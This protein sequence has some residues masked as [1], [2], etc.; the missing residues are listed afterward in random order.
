MRVAVFGCGAF[1]RVH[2]AALAALG[3]EACGVEPD[4]AMHPPG[5]RILSPEAA[6][7]WCDAAIVVT[8]VQSHVDVSSAVLAAGRAL[9]LEKPATETA[10]EAQ[11]LVDLAE[12]RG[13]IAQVGLYF[14]FH[15]KA[16]ALAA[17]VRDGSLGRVHYAA[18]RFSGL[19]RARADSGALLNDAVHFADLLPWLLGEAPRAVFAAMADP[20]GRGREDLAVLHLR[21]PSGAIGLIEAGCVLPGHWPDAVVP[22]AE[23]R[24]E[25]ILAG[26][27]GMAEVDFAAE[28]FRLRRGR[29]RPDAAGAWWPD[30]AP[31]EDPGA[32]AATPHEVVTAEVSTFL[33]AVR[34]GRALGP[35]LREGALAPALL[36]DAARRSAQEGRMVEIG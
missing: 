31:A 30:H 7:H 24:K 4:P 21:F 26:N 3:A 15:P 34:Q 14:R 2:L 35:G 11:A 36:L 9:F 8:P 32:A 17:L 33:D 20:L 25:I 10:A 29:H 12:A 19:K 27:E 18:A 13:A 28:S 22:G 23:T 16:R 1:G 6:L 5:L